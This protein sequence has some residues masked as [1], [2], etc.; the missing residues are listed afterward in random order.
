M[1]PSVVSI[2][3]VALLAACTSDD[4]TRRKPPATPH[5]T[6]SPSPP[7]NTASTPPTPSP[8]GWTTLRLANLGTTVHYGHIVR[9]DPG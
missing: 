7:P 8:A 2:A 6:P 4:G 9:L 5:L 3:L 1:P